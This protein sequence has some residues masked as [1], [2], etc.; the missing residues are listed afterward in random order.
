LEQYAILSNELP[1]NTNI[2][3]C[4][5]TAYNRFG[6]DRPWNQTR[7]KQF[8]ADEELLI[9]RDFWNLICKSPEGYEIVLDEYRKYSAVI[10]QALEDI[11][12]TYLK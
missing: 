2:R 5:A 7:V 6:E 9:G 12:H 1:E 10:L 11:K 3:V 8:F 4:F